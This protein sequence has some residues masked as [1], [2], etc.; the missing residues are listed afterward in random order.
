MQ[1]C[2]EAAGLSQYKDFSAFHLPSMGQTR[3]ALP[4]KRSS[5]ESACPEAKRART[6]LPD[7]VMP[8]SGRAK[9]WNLPEGWACGFKMT[10][11][12]RKVKV[13]VGPCGQVFWDLRQA[14]RAY[15]G[16]L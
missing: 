16:V 5:A 6:A 7:G 3:S 4:E 11:T 14:K 9:A 1:S 2:L 8:L 13:A 12:N 15:P 10:S